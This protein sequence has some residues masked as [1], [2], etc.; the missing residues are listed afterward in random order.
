MNTVYQYSENN[1][2]TYEVHDSTE[3]KHDENQ[4]MITKVSMD[5]PQATQPFFS[6]LY[7]TGATEKIK[8]DMQWSTGDLAA[9]TYFIEYQ[10]KYTKLEC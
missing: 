2:K 7:E 5:D 8:T 10:I 4:L 3:D 1:K 9:G 6:N